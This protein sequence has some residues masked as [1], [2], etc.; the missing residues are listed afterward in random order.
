MLEEQIRDLKMQKYNIDKQVLDSIKT[1]I[2]MSTFN[3]GGDKEEES[4]TAVLMG[5]G[6]GCGILMYM[7]IFIY[8]AQIMQGIIEEK[9]SKVVE[10]IV[11][12]VRPFQLMLGKILG[13]ASVGLLQFLIW[14]VLMMFLTTFV[15]GMIGVDSSAIASPGMPAAKSSGTGRHQPDLIRF[16]ITLYRCQ[17]S[18]LFYR[19]ISPLWSVVR[20]G[21]FC[22]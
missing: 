19:R 2:S 5:I 9:T 7:F 16:Q 4:N 15:L 14:I 8:G 3:L 22:C 17:L 6:V 12:S 11:S 13:L 1:D 18:L 21:R 20:G 10:V